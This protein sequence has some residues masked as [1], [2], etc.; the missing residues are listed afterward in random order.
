MNEKRNRDAEIED[1]RREL[2]YTRRVLQTTMDAIPD[3]IGVQ[4]LEH[5]IIQYNKAGYELVGRTPDAC[6][7]CTCFSLIGRD[8]PCDNCVTA[9]VYRTGRTAE[10]EKYIPEMDKWFHCRAYPVFDDRGEIARVIEHLRDITEERRKREALRESEKRYRHLF[11]YSIDGVL[12]LDEQGAIRQANIRAAD[13]MGYTRDRMLELN[14]RD[15]CRPEDRPRIDAFLAQLRDESQVRIESVLKRKNGSTFPA[16]IAA[17]I[18]SRDNGHFAHA[19]LRDISRRRQIEEGLRQSEEKYRLLVENQTDL[20]IQVDHEWRPLFVSPSYCELF[21]KEERNLLSKP[22]MHKIHEEDIRETAEAIASLDH[23]PRTCYIE[24]RA[25]TKHGWRWLGWNYRA[26]PDEDGSVLHIIGVGRDITARK[27]A[28]AERELLS[29]AI[30]QAAE[31][32]LVTDRSGRIQYV[33][34]AFE[35]ITGYTREEALGRNP[36]I[37]RSGHHDRAFYENMWNTIN[38]GEVW[39]GH[40]INRC[41]DGTLYEEEAFISP[42]K[43]ASGDIRGFVAVKRD[44][45]RERELQQQLIQ[46]QKMEAIGQLAGGIAHDFNNLLLVIKG[47]VELFDYLDESERKDVLVDIGS[48]VDRA[49]SL[50]RQLLAFSRKQA[51]QPRV[52]SM[53]HIIREME[54]LLLRLLGED[55]NLNTHVAADTSNVLVDMGQIEQVLMNLAVNARDAMPRGGILTIRAENV[56]ITRRD[57]GDRKKLAPGRYVLITVS[58]TGPGVPEAIRAHIFEPF[59]TTKGRQKGTGLGLSVV[60]G[61]VRQHNGHIY[62]HNAPEGGAVF[63]MFLPACSREEQEAAAL[64]HGAE[65]IN[66]AGRRILLVEDDAQVRSICAR[67]LQARGFAVDEADSAERAVEL[68]EQENRTYDLLFVDMVMPGESGL[69]FA[70]RIRE[71]HPDWPI[72]LTSGYSEEH[73]HLDLLGKPRFPM[74][75]KPYDLS[76]LYAMIAKQLN[77]T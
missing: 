3:V 69:S 14:F 17:G 72:M 5:R 56:A 62:M 71:K 21:W 47:N 58:D 11:E 77:L 12:I 7:G 43:T 52:T 54:K 36:R 9:E 25:W 24:H 6:H 31:T 46:S 53:A 73:A 39:S 57:V 66:G 65:N 20:I 63:E 42:V 34:P 64:I 35:R 30:E 15:I 32:V 74:I 29:I 8:T 2:E 70:E 68:I 45:T 50:T 33:N 59:F 28:E 13:M 37:L 40:F 1:G 60:Y 76:L 51:I 10:H 22:Y 23:E 41:K 38:A 27:T 44:V 19:Y 67:S 49:A 55:V 4:D 18:F 61:I 75:H 26:I 16:E 48:A